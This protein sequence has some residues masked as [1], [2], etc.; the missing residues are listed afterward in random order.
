MWFAGYECA[1]MHWR[2]PAWRY[3]LWSCSVYQRSIKKVTTISMVSSGP[4]SPI[5]LES[6]AVRGAIWKSQTAS[7]AP[8]CYKLQTGATLS[9]E[10]HTGQW[11]DG[12]FDL[13][14]NS[15]P[16]YNQ[17]PTQHFV[18][19]SVSFWWCH[20]K[21]TLNATRDVTHCRS[22]GVKYYITLL[23]HYPFSWT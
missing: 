19:H 2:S 9:M 23:F 11:E 7:A 12:P 10:P 21:T 4:N 13:A 5:S 3:L 14:W 20:F 16:T 1:L 18:D 17:E 22:S 15:L 8:S 6:M